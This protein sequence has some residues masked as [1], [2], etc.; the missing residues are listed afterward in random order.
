[1]TAL[2]CTIAI[3]LAPAPAECA[4]G[5]HAVHESWMERGGQA[6]II[7]VP[8]TNTDIG[9]RMA[10]A[11]G[12]VGE[13]WVCLQKLWSRESG[14]SETNVTGATVADVGAHRSPRAYGIPQSLPG[15]KMASAGPDWLTNPRTQIAWGLGYIAA[16]YGTPC[17]AYAHSN[18]YSFY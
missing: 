16:R 18:S 11:R 10:A 14:W 2:L 13:Q 1:M 9:R 17:A 6:A 4:R 7:I 12:W 15:W 3:A 5:G 8:E